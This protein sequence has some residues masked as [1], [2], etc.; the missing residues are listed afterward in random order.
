VVII[1]LKSICLP[2]T[3]PLFLPVQKFTSLFSTL[4]SHSLCH[5]FNPPKFITMK[6]ALSLAAVAALATAV[7]LVQRQPSEVT[8]GL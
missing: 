2:A 7:P 4:Y 5:S 3:S 1:L 6:Y 8:D